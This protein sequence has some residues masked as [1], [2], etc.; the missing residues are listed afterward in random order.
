[1]RIISYTVLII[2]Q[3][4]L[5]AS[6]CNV[7][8]LGLGQE[9]RLSPRHPSWFAVFSVHGRHPLDS[10][11][12]TDSIPSESDIV[13]IGAG[14]AGVST[15]YHLLQQHDQSSQPESS[16]VILEARE[17]CSGASGVQLTRPSSGLYLKR[18]QNVLL[19]LCEKH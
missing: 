8:P 14:Y 2:R 10:H 17:I 5:T 7:C 4:P 3:V 1:M 19:H 16:V 18:N 13:V 11:R 15:I 6:R 12:S 9:L